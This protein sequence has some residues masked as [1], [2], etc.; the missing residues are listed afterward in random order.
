MEVDRNSR[1]LRNID[2]H[3]SD[4][5]MPEDYIPSSTLVTGYQITRSQNKEDHNMNLH[6]HENIKISC[7][8]QFVRKIV[9]L[10]TSSF[11]LSLCSCI[12]EMNV[13]GRREL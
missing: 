10:I 7:H 5:M 2:V 3:V 13:C 1:F 11:L 8:Y 4:Y 9:V 6:R 12:S